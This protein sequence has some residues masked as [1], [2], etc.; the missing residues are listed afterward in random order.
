MSTSTPVAV[1]ATAPPGPTSCGNWWRCRTEL[2]FA[3]GVLA[4]AAFMTH[5]IVY[6]EVPE[7]A[8]TPGPQF[9]PAL[10]ALFL[11]VTGVLLAIDVIRNPRHTHPTSSSEHLSTDMLADLA[12]IDDAGLI[13][14]DHPSNAARS[15]L[16][17]SSADAEPEPVGGS[18]HIPVDYR[19]IGLVLGGL[20]GFALLLE[21][22]GWLITAAALFWLVSYA[23]GSKR[24]L[25]DIAVS[26]IV[27]S[28]IQ[29]AFSAGLGLSLPPGI[30]E[31]V[32]PWN[33]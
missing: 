4:I 5:Q 16:P 19:T 9:V 27:A 2:G 3:A 33:N 32:L 31:G 26:V 17:S 21:P 25:F 23:L 29:L 20:V 22:I 13:N 7:G 6:M 18:G 12:A 10:V 8:G 24:Q 14:L 15:E 11:F 1:T 28:V 30:L